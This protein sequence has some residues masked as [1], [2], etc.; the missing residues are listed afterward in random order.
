MIE[1][2]VAAPPYTAA[3]EGRRLKM[4]RAVPYGPNVA[5]RHSHTIVARA[6]DRV[7]NDPWAGTAL[8]KSVSNGVG[9]GI[10]AKAVWGSAE[11]RE[12][13]KRL[14]NEWMAQCD[15][16]GVLDFYGLQ[17][18]A[19][20][21]WHEAGEV[22]IRLRHRLPEDGLVVPLQ[23]QLIEAE[24]CPQHHSAFAPNGNAIRSGI[25]FDRIGRRVAYWMYRTHPGDG[26]VSVDSSNELLRIPAEQIIHLYRPQR[27]GQIRGMPDLAS[28][29]VRMFNL[30]SLDD[31]VLERQKLANMFAGWYVRKT[32]SEDDESAVEGL[33]TEG[34]DDPD[35]PIAGMEPGMMQELPGGVEPKFSDP[36]E[37]GIGYADFYRSQLMAIAARSGVPYEVMTGDLR[38]VSDR[39][40][41]LILNEFRRGIEMDQWLYA[42]PRMCQ[43]VRAAWFDHAY[44]SEALQFDG[45]AYVE[46][47]SAIVE[48]LWTPQGWPYSHPVQDVTADVKAIRAGLT[49]RTKVVMAA[50]EDP[51]EIDA[52]QAEDNT[53]ADTHGLS[54]DS[55]PRVPERASA[56]VAPTAP[57]QATPEGRPR[58]SVD[59]TNDLAQ[60]FG[61]AA[62]MAEAERAAR[63]EQHHAQ[64]G[65]DAI[66]FAVRAR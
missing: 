47:R 63:I 33:L 4:W 16:D 66:G 34:G 51:E 21:E 39:A 43:P 15:A 42:I 65:A 27:A 35:A 5:N 14:W 49:S 11:Y 24:Q 36:P 6:R 52:E 18:L 32:D 61:E 29:L 41:K 12:R 22:F 46:N 13:V 64:R 56:T 38:N 8:D 48:T 2:T 23:L 17:A 44:L 45:H 60:L 37:P 7:R 28:V 20:R 30:D 3:G 62:F 19:W 31:A 9:V 57:I 54:Y 53:R 58:T 10:Q 40:L 25:E 1:R 50:G 59:V 55:D 26:F